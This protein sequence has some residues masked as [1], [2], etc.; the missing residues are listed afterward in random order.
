[1]TIGQKLATYR[2]LAGLTQ[3]QLGEQLNI[4]AQAVSKWENDQAEPDL[5][6]MRILAGLYK[7]SV[8]DLLDPD[9]APHVPAEE[10]ASEEPANAAMPIGFCKHCG[11]AVTEENLGATEPVITCKKC[12]Q[13]EQ[14]AAALAEKKAKEE[15]AHKAARQKQE[16]RARKERYKNRLL[17]SLTVA[18]IA[19]AVFLIVMIIGMTA[20]FNAG[21]LVTT[22]IGTYVVFAFV[23][24]LF[25]DCFVQ[26]VVVDWFDKSLHLPGLIFTFDLDGCLWLIGMKI[27]F[28]ALGLLFGI[29]TGIIGVVLGLICAP[30]V[31][32]Y[33]MA[34]VKDAIRNE[35]KCDLIDDCV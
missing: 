25:Y 6:T 30:F 9:K 2:K 26:E 34:K 10:N 8:D 1:M 16:R 35:K 20:L 29:V 24:S 27:L 15:A 21:M 13:A 12:L 23:A 31:F 17:I 3:Q 18:G 4:S 11:I 7:V 33:V 19:A 22:V 5:S 14:E 28:W 32:P